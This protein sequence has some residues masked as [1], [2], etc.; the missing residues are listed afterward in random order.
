MY[1]IGLSAGRASIPLVAPQ[2]FKMKRAAQQCAI[3]SSSCIKDAQA[4][5]LSNAAKTSVNSFAIPAGMNLKE[6][7]KLAEKIDECQR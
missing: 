2:T 3:L 5:I 4:K 1:E 7:K 6:I